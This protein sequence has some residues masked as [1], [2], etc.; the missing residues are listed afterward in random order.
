MEVNVKNTN[1]IISKVY[2]DSIADELG[3]EVGDLLI[4]I[5]GEPIHDIIEYRFLLSDEY[6][7]L[8][9]QKQN[10]EVYI[11]EIEKDYDD[12]LGIEFTN[13]II[14]KAKSCRNKC[15]FC[16]IDQLPK[17]MRETL[18]FKD[19][20]SRLS[21]LQG[22]FVTLTNMSEEDINNII[23][24]RISPINISVHTTNP[25]LRKTM[26]KNKFAGNLYSIMERLAEA[27]IQMNCQIVLCPGY[28]D[29][30]ELERTVSDLAK[31]Y[32]Y[33]N[34]VAAVPV[35]ITKH[36]DHLPNLEIFNKQTAGETIDQV[37]KLHHKYL[38]ELGTRF[39]FL[40]DEFYIMANRKLLNYDEYEGFIQFENGVGMISKFEREIEDYLENLSE[41][42]KSKIKKVS[43]ATGHSAY[44]FMC[45]MAKCIM[46]KCPNVQIDVYKIINNFFGDTITVSGLVTATDIIDQL[47]D[48]DLGETLY[49]PRSMLKADEEI[50]LDNITLE[51][52][53]N[54]MEIEVVPCLN[55]GK[56]FIDKI[57]K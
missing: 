41:D 36:R 6:L 13:P 53:S 56:D 17:G 1:N 5:N 35:G 39:I 31:L 37:E 48:K 24:Y 49:I 28:N 20:D 15:V 12:D 4:S 22:N 43:I 45:E 26:I 16:F 2:K 55:E 30:K 14:D 23:K 32:P 46:E 19:D 50:F 27:Q 44:E 33:V 3:I 29:K 21:F 40:S 11:Y 47:K 38:K 25:E 34:S 52:I 10:R 42:Y 8:E 9:I 51:E 18:Y 54:I 7:E 57:L